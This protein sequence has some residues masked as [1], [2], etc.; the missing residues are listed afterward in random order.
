[1]DDAKATAA[2][3]AFERAYKSPDVLQ[4][5]THETP[6]EFDELWSLLKEPLAKINYRGEIRT[7]AAG[8]RQRLPDKVQLF[9]ALFFLRQYPTYAVLS[10][11]LGGLSP[12]VFASLHL[13]GPHSSVWARRACYQVAHRR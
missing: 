5:L 8:A 7:R 10:Y 12:P 9:I 11:A 6:A 4:K 3:E 1:V 13:Q 2:E